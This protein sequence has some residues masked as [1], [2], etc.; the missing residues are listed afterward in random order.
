MSY[1]ITISDSQVGIDN[2]QCEVEMDRIVLFEG[3]MKECQE[4]IKKSKNITLA[5]E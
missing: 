1:I 3:K 5:V 4:F 2:P